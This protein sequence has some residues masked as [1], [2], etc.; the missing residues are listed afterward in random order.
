MGSARICRLFLG[1]LGIPGKCL[2]GRHRGSQVSSMLCPPST[3]VASL[4][5]GLHFS[6]SRHT[7][8]KFEG[9]ALTQSPYFIAGKWRARVT[10]PGRGEPAREQTSCPALSLES[11]SPGQSEPPNQMTEVFLPETTTG[12]T[13]GMKRGLGHLNTIQISTF[14]PSVGRVLIWGSEKMDK[15]G[16]GRRPNIQRWP[17]SAL[18]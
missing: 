1:S 6:G 13:H 14:C 10:Q 9:A 17:F 18:R 5:A 16:S 3:T 15:T 11:P 12:K 2:V 7:K 8:S 4:L